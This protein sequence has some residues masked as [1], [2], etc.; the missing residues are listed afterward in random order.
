MSS[1]GLLL[2]EEVPP[3]RCGGKSFMTLACALGL[4]LAALIAVTISG[5][6]MMNEPSIDMAWRPTLSKPQNMMPLKSVP[7]MPPPPKAFPFMQ[8]SV[9]PA[10]P[11]PI[12]RNVGF[13]TQA[14]QNPSALGGSGMNQNG[15]PDVRTAL[16]LSP[17]PKCLYANQHASLCGNVVVL[18]PDTALRASNF[19]AEEI[20]KDVTDKWDAVEDKPGTLLTA[21]GVVIALTLTNSIISTLDA[22]PLLPGLLKTVGLGYSGYFAYR[23]LFT[24]ASRQELK[25]DIDELKKKVS[26]S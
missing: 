9:A 24:A 20:L 12:S 8:S 7:A 4:G 21:G 26:G 11:G 3:A 19:D 15:F 14:L 1:S 17:A 22:I 10:I 13:R 16:S 2:K 18:R 6:Q 5:G 23:Y 25:E